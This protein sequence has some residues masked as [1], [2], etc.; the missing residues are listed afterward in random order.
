[1]RN[2]DD[3]T[4]IVRIATMRAASRLAAMEGVPSGLRN[5]IVGSVATR[6]STHR[7]GEVLGATFLPSPEVQLEIKDLLPT[8]GQLDR[9]RA[10]SIIRDVALLRP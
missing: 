3:P 5:E 10:Y 6:L 7:R 4:Q 1:V 9:E 8:F 2:L